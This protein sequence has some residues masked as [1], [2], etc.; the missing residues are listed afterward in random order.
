MA[1]ETTYFRVDEKYKTGGKSVA[2]NNCHKMR[3]TSDSWVAPVCPLA[4]FIFISRV[5]FPS[6]LSAIGR[7]SFAYW[8]SAL[9]LSVAAE[10]VSFRR[11]SEAERSP[12]GIDGYR[13]GDL[14]LDPFDLADDEVG[15]FFF[16]RS[17]FTLSRD[18]SSVCVDEVL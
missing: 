10:L 18:C 2:C 12:A 4:L 13:A 15:V 14:G 9:A 3:R 6:F 16:C 11:K 1:A 5:W 8:G 7:V 17:A